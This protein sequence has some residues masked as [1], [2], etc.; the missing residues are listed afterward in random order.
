MVSENLYPSEL[1]ASVCEA[2]MLHRMQ[3]K[4]AVGLFDFQYWRRGEWSRTS[5]LH[6]YRL[7]WKS[8]NSH[9]Q[10]PFGQHDSHTL[11]SRALPGGDP[12]PLPRPIDR[13]I[14]YAT[15]ENFLRNY[16]STYYLTVRWFSHVSLSL[17]WGMRS[18]NSV[19]GQTAS[20]SAKTPSW[21]TPP[22]IFFCFTPS[23]DIAE[24]NISPCGEK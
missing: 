22:I 23:I 11:T 21:R 2:C 12:A 14:W 5:T 20:L 7:W 6:P 8:R 17:Q 4:W 3:I 18:A 19:Q 16:V 9:I 13:S 15:W 1:A 24:Q 10:S